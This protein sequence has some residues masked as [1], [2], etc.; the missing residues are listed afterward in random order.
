MME[1]EGGSVG[2]ILITGANRGIGLELCRQ[3]S[4]RGDEVITWCKSEMANYKVPR[5]VVEHGGPLPRGMSG[6]ILKRELR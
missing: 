4:E 3:L 2:R 1:S 5:Y 6:K